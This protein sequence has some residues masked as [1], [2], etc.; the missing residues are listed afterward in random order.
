[1]IK[2]CPNVGDGTTPDPHYDKG[3]DIYSLMHYSGY[4]FST[5][6]KPT[7]I[8]RSTNKPVPDNRRISQSDFDLV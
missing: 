2:G 7:I 3:Y 8:D 6:G 4:S 5:N 1:M